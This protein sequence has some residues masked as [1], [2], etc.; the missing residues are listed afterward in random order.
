MNTGKQNFLNCSLLISG[1]IV[2]KLKCFRQQSDHQICSN[3]KT[4]M[5]SV[6]RKITQMQSRYRTKRTNRISAHEILLLTGW[7]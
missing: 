2:A 1:E 5:N 4:G 6:V 7:L 3:E